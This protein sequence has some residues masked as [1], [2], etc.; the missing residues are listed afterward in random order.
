MIIDTCVNQ[1]SKDAEVQVS[2]DIME[3]KKEYILW[4]C[5]QEYVIILL[6][7]SVLTIIPHQDIKFNDKLLMMAHFMI[8]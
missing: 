3:T 8:L 2:F 7:F 1:K 5:R 6:I 4:K